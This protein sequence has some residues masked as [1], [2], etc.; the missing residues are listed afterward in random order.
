MGVRGVKHFVVPAG[1][2]VIVGERRTHFQVSFEPLY[3]FQV[4]LRA[5]FGQAS[6]VELPRGAEL[7]HSK[8]EDLEVAEK[9]ILELGAPVYFDHGDHVAVEGV[10]QLAVDCTGAQVLDE[11]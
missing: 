9:L 6:H 2:R 11:G 5:S 10:K 1:S 3:G 7:L 4:V 8:Q